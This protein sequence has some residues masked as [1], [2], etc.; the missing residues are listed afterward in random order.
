MVFKDF[1]AFGVWQHKVKIPF[2]EI[3]LVRFEDRYSVNWISYLCSD[4]S[5]HTGK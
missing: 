1:D 2:S 4:K 5:K 3:A